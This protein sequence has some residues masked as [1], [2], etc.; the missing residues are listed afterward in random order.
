MADNKG[1][2]KLHRDIMKK[3]IYDDARTFKAF[4]HL[5][6]TV[7]IEDKKTKIDGNFALV[8]RG[9]R[10]TSVSTLSEELKFTRRTVS[11]ILEDLEKNE[12]IKLQPIGRGFIVT[13][14]NY[15]IYQSA[16]AS[17]LPS[18]IPSSMPST[19]KNT[20]PSAQLK[21]DK[22]QM[23]MGKEK[24]IKNPPKRVGWSGKGERPE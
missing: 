20:I 16:L 1:W 18:T 21:K 2:I 13:V 12:A 4:M 14:T 19:I 3:W 23:R 9:Q 15:E 17:T 7:N 8:E 10:I 5:C 24:P 6:M 11:Q 22:K